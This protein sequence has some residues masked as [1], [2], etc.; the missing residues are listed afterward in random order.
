MTPEERLNRTPVVGEWTSRRLKTTLLA[1]A[2]S[3]LVSTC[4]LADSGQA[5]DSRTAF[6]KL[7][8]LAGDWQ[9][10]VPGQKDPVK[11]TYRVT[12]AGSALLETIM[13]DT[14]H[15]MVT[16]YHLDGSKLVLTHFCAVGNQPKM[17]LVT[18]SSNQQQL[19]FDFAG[20]ANVRP[21]KDAHMHSMRMHF[22][23]PDQITAEWDFHKEGK[24][25][26]TEKFTLTKLKS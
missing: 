23:G 24:K 5:T 15:E 9:G 8:T 22:D 13:P 25:Q 4:A 19:Q 17:V 7:K 14:P 2:G 18:K 10:T 21:R 12:S 11:V 1:L 16:V 20:G 6:E 26:S 3:C